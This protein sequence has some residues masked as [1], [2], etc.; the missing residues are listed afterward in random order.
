MEEDKKK[1]D[2]QDVENNNKDGTS[3]SKTTQA[4]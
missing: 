4:Q 2:K 1:K 3:R